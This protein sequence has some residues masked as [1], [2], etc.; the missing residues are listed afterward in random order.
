[1]TSDNGVHRIR[2]RLEEVLDDVK[3]LDGQLATPL[4]LEPS[5]C[6]LERTIEVYER[7]DA[8]NSN[9]EDDR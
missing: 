2:I 6:N 1:M 9:T 5:I 3:A 7:L 8:E 4:S